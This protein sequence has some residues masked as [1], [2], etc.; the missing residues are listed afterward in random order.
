M[1]LLGLIRALGPYGTCCFPSAMSDSEAF[2][3]YYYLAQHALGKRPPR[4]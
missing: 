3:Q 2:D 1:M 4:R